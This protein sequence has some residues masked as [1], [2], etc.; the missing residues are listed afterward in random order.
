MM[1]GRCPKVMDL[2]EIFTSILILEGVL[3]GEWRNFYA[4]DDN[5]FLISYYARVSYLI[6]SMT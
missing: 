2:D 1:Q 3:H 4:P 5:D 6:I